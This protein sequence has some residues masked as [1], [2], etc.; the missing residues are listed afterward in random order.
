[1]YSCYFYSCVDI[2]FFFDNKC[3]ILKNLARYTYRYCIIIFL[4]IRTK[5]FLDSYLDQFSDTLAKLFFPSMIFR[6][7]VN[8]SVYTNF[9]STVVRLAP[10]VSNAKRHRNA[11]SETHACTTAAVR[12]SV[13]A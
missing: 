5:L 6:V 10:T 12:I 7:N 13:P 1:M 9:Q 4:I 8:L 2:I 3:K 11:V